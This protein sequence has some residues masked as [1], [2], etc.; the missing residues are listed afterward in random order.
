VVFVL[1]RS[2]ALRQ[3]L[4]EEIAARVKEARQSSDELSTVSDELSQLYHHTC[5][6]SGDTPQRIVLDSIKSKV[7]LISV[8]SAS[9]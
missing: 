4:S 2:S 1:I 6:A 3:A 7:L 8:F 5:L 9:S